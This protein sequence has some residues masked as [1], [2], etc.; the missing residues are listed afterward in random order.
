M[1]D[2]LQPHRLQ[3][4]RLPCSSLSP[5]FCSNSCSLSLSCHSTIP[6]SVAPFVSCPQSFP[7]SGSFPISLLLVSVGQSI[8]A[9]ASA[10][11][12]SMNIQSWFPLALTG[13]T[14]MLSKGLSRI[15]SST[16]VGKHQFFSDQT[17]LW[18]NSLIQ[19]MTT[20][21]W[22]YGPLLAKWCLCFKKK[23]FICFNWRI[24][25]L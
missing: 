13:L 15:F 14:S 20:I 11:V 9:S 10:S 23:L 1:C 3:R 25:N 4:A 18:S 8:G 21:P 19:T 5:K 16:T 22:L 6:F 12:F 17:S 24:I 7:A 2:S